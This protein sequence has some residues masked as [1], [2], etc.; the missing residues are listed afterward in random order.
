VVAVV[1]KS[2]GGS[3]GSSGGK[4]NTVSGGLDYTNHQRRRWAAAHGEIYA[5]ELHI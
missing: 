5:D 1:A 4:I 2:T 3:S